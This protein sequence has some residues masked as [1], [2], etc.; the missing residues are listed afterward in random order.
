MLLE[1]ERKARK[2]PDYAE[3]ADE[4]ASEEDEEILKEVFLEGE[5]A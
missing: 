1:D 5:T 3:L 2:R 4:D